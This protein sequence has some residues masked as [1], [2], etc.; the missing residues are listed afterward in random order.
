M[1]P[2]YLASSVS[3]PSSRL[4]RCGGEISGR[5]RPV[6]KESTRS[7]HSRDQNWG[8]EDMDYPKN[9]RL[10]HGL[11]AFRAVAH[12]PPS[13][14]IHHDYSITN[15]GENPGRGFYHPGHDCWAAIESFTT[16]NLATVSWGM[17][18]LCYSITNVTS[19]VALTDIQIGQGALNLPL[20]RT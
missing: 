10:R 2:S 5:K 17:A 6:K 14:L 9:S 4:Q 12:S 3:S 19:H 15:C 13:S 16:A 11:L 7:E 1:S 20:R 8:G 18:D